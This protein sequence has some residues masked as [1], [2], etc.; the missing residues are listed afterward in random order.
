MSYFNTMA[1]ES[2]FLLMGLSFCS[3]LAFALICL[4]WKIP[5]LKISVFNA[6]WVS[7]DKYQFGVTEIILGWL[8]LGSY[9]KQKE[10]NF[11]E[12]SEE[13][14]EQKF[15]PMPVFAQGK[16]LGFLFKSIPLI[17]WLLILTILTLVLSSDSSAVFLLIVDLLISVFQDLFYSNSLSPN[18][19]EIAE[20]ISVQTNKY[21]LP[22]FIYGSVHIL[23]KIVSINYGKTI[24]RL[25]GK[26][27]K[28]LSSGKWLI[29]FWLLLW[30]LPV[31]FLSIF[32]L[33]VVSVA[34]YSY[35]LGVFISGGIIFYV[36]VAL[37]SLKSRF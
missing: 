6:P 19:L 28:L 21:F 8:P 18:S 11:V 34:F 13:L 3:I 33:S 20:S 35:L 1:F 31:L 5:I 16:L 17:I 36:F 23:L 14:Y 30:K 27:F 29:M 37:L 22:I 10:A 4:V 2:G 24:F 26:V 12:E 15:N 7:I 32:S 25:K 9:L